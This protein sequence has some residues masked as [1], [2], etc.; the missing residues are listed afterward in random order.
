MTIWTKI[1][2]LFGWHDWWLEY[3]VDYPPEGSHRHCRHCQKF[4]LCDWGDLTGEIYWT[5]I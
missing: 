3:P 2:C 4:Q 1:K 5:T